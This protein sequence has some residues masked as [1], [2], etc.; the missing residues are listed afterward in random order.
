VEFI[1]RL[2]LTRGWIT[3]PQ[4]GTSP[5]WPGDAGPAFYNA[6]PPNLA[7]Q[8]NGSVSYLGPGDVIIINVFRDGKADGGHALVVNEASDMT[9]GTVNLVS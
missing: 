2:Y 7:R 1:N 8:R 5:A 4:N 6:A 3:G 9:S